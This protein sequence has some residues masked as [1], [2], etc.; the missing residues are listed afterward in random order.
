[1]SDVVILPAF[2]LV[3]T[4][5]FC[6]ISSKESL[7]YAQVYVYVDVNCSY[8]EAILKSAI[9]R[10]PWCTLVTSIH[11]HDNTYQICDFENIDWENVLNNKTHASSYLIRK[12]LSR[13]SR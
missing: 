1:M 7:N 10:R 11:D 3:S 12:G 8:S 6:V 2:G 5:K 9:L 13:Y 4:P